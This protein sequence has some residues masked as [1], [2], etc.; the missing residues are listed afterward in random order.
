M[1]PRVVLEAVRGRLEDRAG[2]ARTAA[3]RARVGSDRRERLLGQYGAFT[4]AAH[5]ITRA[6]REID[7]QP[8]ED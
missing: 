2:A 7:P 4:I 5:E 6:L 8:T 3:R 1:T